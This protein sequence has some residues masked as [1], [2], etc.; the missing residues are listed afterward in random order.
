MIRTGNRDRSRDRRK[1]AK[2]DLKQYGF[3]PSLEEIN[4]E[5]K[6]RTEASDR[7]KIYK[8]FLSSLIVVAAFTVLIATLWLPVMKVN[9]TSMEPLLID[10]DIIV[11][12]KDV[13]LI[14]HGDIIAFYYNDKVLLK[15]VLG[16]PGDTVMVDKSGKV[17][18]NN[19][20]IDE[21]YIYEKSLGICNV[22][23]PVKVQEN[24]FFVLGDNRAVS[25]DSRSADVGN[26]HFERVVGKIVLRVY[27]FQRM[28]SVTN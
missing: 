24:S 13:N 3:M 15:R 25:I 22:T 9:G 4:M 26:I 12:V 1:D 11:A 16:L 18:V 19:K 23:M 28:G 8:K 21:P 27:P 10:G 6:R 5:L 17:Y 7:Y 20:Y 14:K 2:N